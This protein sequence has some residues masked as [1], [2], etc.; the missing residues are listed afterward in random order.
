[1]KK[2]F[3]TLLSF[4]ILFTLSS[5][6]NNDGIMESE[7]TTQN[8]T[9]IDTSHAETTTTGE[10]VQGLL[11]FT[12]VPLTA[13][14]N[15]PI[16]DVPEEEYDILRENDRVRVIGEDDSVYL[17]YEDVYYLVWDMDVPVSQYGVVYFTDLDHEGTEEIFIKNRINDR[18]MILA[19]DPDLNA[20][21]IVLE[22]DT[23]DI[24][25]INDTSTPEY[26]LYSVGAKQFPYRLII[27]PFQNGR[28][29]IQDVSLATDSDF[30]VILEGKYIFAGTDDDISM[31]T[32]SGTDL[33]KMNASPYIASVSIIP[34]SDK[35]VL[36]YQDLNKISRKYRPLSAINEIYARHGYIFDDE[37][38]QQYYYYNPW[39]KTDADFDET[40]LTETEKANIDLIN[41]YMALITANATVKYDEMQVSL[42][43]NGDGKTDD[44]SFV[45]DEGN[46]S[47]TVTIN[48]K[49]AE[50]SGDWMTNAIY[51]LDLDASDSYK[52]IAVTDEG[53][54]NDC[55]TY[56][57]TYDGRDIKLMGAVEGSADDIS[58]IGSGGIVAYRRGSVLQTWF[59]R[60]AYKTGGDRNLIGID[61][62]EYTVNTFVIL[63]EDLEVYNSKTDRELNFMIKA[64]EPALIVSSDDKDTCLI[65]NGSGDEGYFYVK[66]FNE[67][68]NTGIASG[69]YFDGLVF[70]D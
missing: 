25:E 54:S 14:V 64:G 70:A 65:R 27:Y 5:C 9:S 46:C 59:Y 10:T 11:E 48:D 40:M 34:D 7:T 15:D 3:V 19:Y 16:Q 1:M 8:D 63:K 37:E 45:I 22:A 32:L 23:I 38:M 36:T 57:Y 30:S 43:M 21:D 47:Y 51:V 18:T 2:I 50:G 53:S 67:I 62:D 69:D 17:R 33:N 31:Y 42:D 13:L 35:K 6:R 60:Y 58:L 55:I 39:Y 28:F 29:Y 41:S 4:S 52:E 24:S 49:T 56:I 66:N 20:Y 61:E 68:N 26:L 44:V 12:P